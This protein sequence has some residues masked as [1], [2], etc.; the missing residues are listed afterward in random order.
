MIP[1]YQAWH[2]RQLVSL[3][4]PD[5]AGMWQREILATARGISRDS[6]QPFDDM[7]FHVASK[8]RLGAYYMI[9]LRQSTCDCQDFPRLR[10]CKHIAAIYVHFPHLS[11]EGSTPTLDTEAVQY[12]GNPQRIVRQ[13]D[14]LCALMHNIRIL[15]QQLTS[16]D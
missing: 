13:E 3:E 10:F 15:S 11:P 16:N 5:L 9:D 14:T 7:Q 1:H 2:A 12:V 4:G 6:I 8:S